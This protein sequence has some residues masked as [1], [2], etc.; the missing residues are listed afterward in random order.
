MD[1]KIELIHGDCV[2]AL[3]SLPDESVDLILT[4]PPYGIAYVS[5]QRT[6]SD[7]FEMLQNDNNDIR[8]VAYE[9]FDRILKPNSCV[10]VFASWKNQAADQIELAKYFDIKNVLIWWKRGGGIGD[11]EHSLSTDYEV[12]IVCHKGSCKIR[13]KR[14]GSVFVIDK[15]NPNEMVHP[16][17]KPIELMSRIMAKFTDP[18][19][20]VCDPFMGS[21]TT[22]LAAINMDRNF[23]G[24]EI[25]PKYY[26][27]ASDL[28]DAAQ[29][30]IR[31]F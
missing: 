15:V 11:L 10:I 8:F 31:M 13:G 23:I 29:S 18:G 14:D 25:D 28:V 7:K 22:A 12:A 6:V 21:G 17:Q 26:N 9:E 19:M 16:T 4:D 20:T 30:Q 24:M 5:N 3:K 1:N 2:E 27:I